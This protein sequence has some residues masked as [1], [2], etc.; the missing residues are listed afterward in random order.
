MVTDH[1]FMADA[2]K[3]FGAIMPGEIKVFP[4]GEIEQALAWAG[5]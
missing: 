4:D 1:K 2:I 3:V 5:G